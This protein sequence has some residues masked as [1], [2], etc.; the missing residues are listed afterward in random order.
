MP[1]KDTALSVTYYNRTA[2]HN[3]ALGIEVRNCY[4]ICS[5]VDLSKECRTVRLQFLQLPPSLFQVEEKQ[6]EKTVDDID[7]MRNEV[8]VFNTNCPECN[9]PANTNMKLVRIL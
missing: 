6:D 1:Q 7:A 9:A 3:A 4:R 2:E 8:L 5:A